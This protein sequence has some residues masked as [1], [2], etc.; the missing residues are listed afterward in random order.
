MKKK[1]YIFIIIALVCLFPIKTF[2]FFA[3]PDLRVRS[4]PFGENKVKTNIKELPIL[5]ELV[6][7]QEFSQTNSALLQPASL[8][9]SENWPSSLAWLTFLTAVIIAIII[10][11]LFKFRKML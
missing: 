4:M 6:Q 9:I 8:N 5:P 7:T 3:T 1:I 2:S 11:I 10:F